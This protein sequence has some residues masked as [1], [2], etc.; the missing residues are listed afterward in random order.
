MSEIKYGNLLIVDDEQLILDKTQIILEDYA[1][2]VFTAESGKK[3]IE[4]LK[5]ETIHC[6]VCD[7]NMPEM[8]GIEVIKAVREMGFEIP[9]IS[10][11]PTCPC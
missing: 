6:I 8:N 7:I 1:D 3:A 10:Q 2:S 9:F 4:I 11:H 5:E